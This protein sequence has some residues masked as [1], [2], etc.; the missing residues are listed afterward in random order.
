[1]NNTLMP[2]GSMRFAALAAKVGGQPVPVPEGKRILPYGSDHAARLVSKLLVEG[3][4]AAG[5]RRV[6]RKN[7]LR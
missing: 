2:Y 3:K 5:Q 4:T 1:M 6:V 7:A